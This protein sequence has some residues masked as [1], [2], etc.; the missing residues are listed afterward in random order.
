MIY[1]A[2][3]HVVY[4]SADDSVP[5]QKVV[6]VIDAVQAATQPHKTLGPVPE[7]LGKIRPDNLDLEIRLVT[8]GSANKPCHNDCDSR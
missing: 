1:S 6:E 2:R 3:R 4:L 7:G 5:F 8:P